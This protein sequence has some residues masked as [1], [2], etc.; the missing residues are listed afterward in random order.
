[1]LYVFD[2]NET[3]LDLA[4][5]DGDPVERDEVFGSTWFTL[6]IR[7]SHVSAA[8]GAYRDFGD[9]G[10]A[11]GRYLGVDDA[12]MGRVARAM[13]E[14]PP[15]P[16]VVPGLQRTLRPTGW[17]STARA[18]GRV[19]RRWSRRTTGTSPVRPLP[20]CALCWSRAATSVRCRSTRSPT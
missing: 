3:M 12:V 7:T 14:L 6:V 20:G 11:A 5:L 18:C 10:A 2:I 16:D 9:I 1:M 17:C 19:T 13:R 15:H 8:T 4:A